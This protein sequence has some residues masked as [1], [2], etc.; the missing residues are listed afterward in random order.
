MATRASCNSWYRQMRYRAVGATT[1][2][3]AVPWS[4]D[5]CVPFNPSLPPRERVKPHGPRHHQPRFAPKRAANTAPGHT[6][7][8]SPASPHLPGIGFALCP[9]Q[10][11]PAFSPWFDA[12]QVG[13][14]FPAFFFFFFFP[15]SRPGVFF[16]GVLCE[17]Q[18]PARI[19]AGRTHATSP[20]G[21]PVGDNTPPRSPTAFA[22]GWSGA[23]PTRRQIPAN[24]A[25]L[26]GR[27]VGERSD[28]PSGRG[29]GRHNH[30]KL[31]GP[32]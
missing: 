11:G 19:C 7:Q 3:C 9:S 27:G 31:L 32:S 13:F 2:D 22:P 15:I 26:T 5:G 24:V 30:V 1:A 29:R 10:P 12:W 16:L 18:R 17:I 23:V 4:I 28:V 6:A 14:V 21:D 8:P 25:G 20:P